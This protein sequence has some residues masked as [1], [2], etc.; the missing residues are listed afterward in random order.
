[1][2]EPADA[3]R[4][5]TAL[6]AEQRGRRSITLATL[7]ARTGIPK[8]RLQRILAPGGQR[9]LINELVT[10]CDALGVPRSD[11][12]RALWPTQT[13]TGEPSLGATPD[14]VGTLEPEVRA[15]AALI[16][17][18]SRST[19]W[20]FSVEPV[21]AGPSDQ[22]RVHAHTSVSARPADSD[23][24]GHDQLRARF[25]D[26]FGG[27]PPGVGFALPRRPESG[28]RDSGELGFT[29][30]V[31]AADRPASAVPLDLR[32]AAG[33]GIAVVSLRLMG[34]AVRLGAVLARVLGWGLRSTTRTGQAVSRQ[35][36]P[37]ARASSAK[38]MLY[39]NLVLGELLAARPSH[40]VIGHVGTPIVDSDGRLLEEHS[41]LTADTS[42][43]PFVVLISES[44]AALAHGLGRPVNA[45]GDTSRFGFRDLQLWRDQLRAN[46]LRL[47]DED[48]GI[49]VDLDPPWAT[50]AVPQAEE[51]MLGWRETSRQA[52]IVLTQLLRLSG[53]PR[54]SFA[55]RDEQARSLLAFDSAVTWR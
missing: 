17:L 20:S 51:S 3:E 35:A 39:A 18:L 14:P 6:L 1:M 52:R 16:S 42:R 8:H 32:G 15:S 27:L 7:S 55:S 49:V 29:C 10:L 47:Q 45:R 43:G 41:L 23:A 53:I 22:V 33:G 37:D 13:L 24:V 9:L 19:D 28:P 48:R 12:V 46:V 31:F 25:T 4:R 21:F 44:D 38:E 30:S 5:L 36:D 54:G 2:T 50:S 40:T 34:R 26:E 11:V